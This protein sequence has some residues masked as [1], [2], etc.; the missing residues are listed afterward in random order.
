MHNALQQKNAEAYS[1]K[2]RK[3]SFKNSANFSLTTRLIFP[4]VLFREYFLQ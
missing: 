2:A 3:I 4:V 1:T